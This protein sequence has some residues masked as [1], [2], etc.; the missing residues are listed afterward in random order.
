MHH[1]FFNMKGIPGSELPPTREGTDLFQVQE[2]I[3]SLLKTGKD[4]HDLDLTGEEETHLGF[5]VMRV[6]SPESYFSASSMQL[7]KQFNFQV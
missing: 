6:W 1:R 2:M 7:N 4:L 3:R 5:K